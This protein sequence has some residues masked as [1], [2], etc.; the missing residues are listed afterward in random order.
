MVSNLIQYTIH[1]TPYTVTRNDSQNDN[2]TL[3]SWTQFNPFDIIIVTRND[4][5][6]EEMTVKMQLPLLK[7]KK[8][9]PPLF[10][11]NIC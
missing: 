3:I 10:P 8:G 4:S 6:F 11:I 5:S 9:L 1:L 2:L 7:R